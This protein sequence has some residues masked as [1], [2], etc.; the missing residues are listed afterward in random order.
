MSLWSDSHMSMNANFSAS[1]MSAFIAAG[2]NFGIETAIPG[3][4]MFCEGLDTTPFD[5]SD[6]Y[7]L[8]N[9]I[10]PEAMPLAPVSDASFSRLPAA[11]YAVVRR[12]DFVC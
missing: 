7:L 12:F 10:Q 3:S 9:S 6:R 5:Y 11:R 8:Q 4:Q 1:Q 2:C